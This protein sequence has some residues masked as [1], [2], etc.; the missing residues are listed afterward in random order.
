MA[1]NLAPF[2]RWTL[3]DKAPQRRLVRWASESPPALP[4]KMS[5]TKH[6][7]TMLPAPFIVQTCENRIRDTRRVP[8]QGSSGSQFIPF[9]TGDPFGLRKAILPVFERMPDGRLIGMGTAVHLDGWGGCLTAEH[10]V[11]FVR[12]RL[13]DGGLHGGPTMEVDPSQHSHPVLLLGIGVVFGTVAIPDWAFAPITD[14]LTVA[15]ERDDP[16]A[17]LQDRRRFEVA[18]DVARVQALFHPDAYREPN[19]PQVLP[20]QLRGWQP[21]IG[22]YVLAF[23]YPELKPSMAMSDSEVRAIIEDGLHCA[24]GRITRLFPDGRDLTNP[25]PVFEVEAN[26]PS[27]M[28]GGPVVNEQGNVVGIV[29]RSLAPDGDLSGVGYAACLPWISEITSL[30]PHLDKDNPGHRL[31]FAVLD[32]REKL[33]GVWPTLELAR[34]YATQD[35]K[36]KVFACSHRMGSD[37]YICISQ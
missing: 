1:L 21:A 6:S 30:A 20:L 16:M 23:G 18:Q 5:M 13:P 3:C 19:P 25:T 36:C 10:V 35:T 14:T 37:E 32:Y 2:S 7:S 26:W 15:R 24:Y 12:A 8:F 33:V 28:S 27:G 17:A 22:E 34:D 29:S 31:G 4:L 9:E 11:D